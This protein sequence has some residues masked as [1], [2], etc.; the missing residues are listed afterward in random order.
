MVGGRPAA[1]AD[2]I[3]ETVAGEGLE[4]GCGVLRALGETG[5]REGVGQAGVGVAGDEGVGL[6][7]ELLD[8]RAHLLAA[9][10]AVEPDGQR[11][12]V[13]DG[14][15]EGLD[16]LP[17]QGAA[18]GVGDGPRDEEGDARAARLEGLV[19]RH[20]RGLEHEGVEDRLAEEAVGAGVEQGV[21]LLAVGVAHLVE[22]DVALAGVGDVPAH[23]EGLVGR[24]DGAGHEAGPARRRGLGG[25]GGLAGDGHRGRVDLP[26]EVG[27]AVFLLGDG[28]AV[29]GVRLDQVGAGLEVG[30]MDGLDRVGLGQDEQVVVALEVA[31]VV[32]QTLA[33]VVGL[34]ELQP[35]E[36]GAHGPVEVDEALPEQRLEAPAGRVEREL[37]GHRLHPATLPETVKEGDSGSG[38]WGAGGGAGG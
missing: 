25:L 1:A 8:V 37:G 11:L 18:G 7:G 15:P 30:A 5:G 26:D 27:Q 32:L 17:G 3:H 31:G 16:R 12:G 24:A 33:P 29:E 19:D 14:V 6:A 38:E 28:G 36:H 20:E 34:R 9:E 4:D 10:G 2:E 35:L 21:H 22:G 13:A 23:R